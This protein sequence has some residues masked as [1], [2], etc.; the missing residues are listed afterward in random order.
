MPTVY[1]SKSPLKKT[2]REAKR[3]TYLQAIKRGVTRHQACIQAGLEPH[4]A[5]RINRRLAETCSLGDRPLSGRP[6]LHTD[7]V[8]QDAE[9]VWAKSPCMQKTKTAV[10]PCVLKHCILY[11]GANKA[12]FMHACH[13]FCTVSTIGSLLQAPA[14]VSSSSHKTRVS[15]CSTPSICWSVWLIGMH[16]GQFYW[17]S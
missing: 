14:P 9:A 17:V 4:A 12:D 3:T 15:V 16:G 7:Q 2:Q 1:K 10:V 5:M 6:H 8:F 13:Q 11:Q